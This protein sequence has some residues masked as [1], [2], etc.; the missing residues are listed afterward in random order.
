MAHTLR[1]FLNQDHNRRTLGYYSMFICLGMNL[2]VIGPTLPALAEQ[3]STRLGLMGSLFLLSSVGYVIGTLIAGSAFDRFRGH[4]MLGAAGLLSATMLALIPLAPTFPILLA[5]VIVRGMA[6]GMINTG[7]NALLLWTHGDDSPPYM[8]GLHL[9]FGAGAFLSPLIAAPVLENQL[10]IGLVYWLLAGISMLISIRMLLDPGSP[11]P[12]NTNP[13]SSSLQ[14]RPS[15]RQ[16]P[17]VLLL[18]FFLFF[19]VGAEVTFGGWLYSFAIT[20]DLTS[21]ANAAYLT[22]AFYLA[23]TLGRLIAIPMTSRIAVDT[24]LRFSLIGCL[25][26]LGIG[27]LFFK[28]PPVLWIMAAGTGLFMAP[29]FPAAFSFAGQIIRMDARASSRVLL[30]DSFG[31]MILPW[32]AGFL[33]ESTTPVSL[34]YLVGGSVV[35]NMAV[36]AVFLN[37]RR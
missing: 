15:G 3:T 20:L 9:A 29:V 14:R 11:D 33:I 7:N 18:A 17:V 4:P 8:T 32:I 6:D 23:F 19:Y 13:D 12:G 22:S 35:I 36:F 31:G 28:Y 26:T 37:T 27:T 30:G 16:A 21:E 25:L 34:L 10:P 2:A 5:I 1:H 24:V